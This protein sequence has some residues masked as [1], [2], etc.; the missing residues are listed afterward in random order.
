MNVIAVGQ[1]FYI[2]IQTTP[3]RAKFQVH[4]SIFKLQTSSHL[5]TVVQ[6]EFTINDQISKFYSH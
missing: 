3:F 4:L 2:V 5:Q 1:R 6:A